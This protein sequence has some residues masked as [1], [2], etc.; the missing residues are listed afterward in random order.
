VLS[1]LLA[2]SHLGRSSEHRRMGRVRVKPS[3]ATS[4]M[5][6]VVGAVFVGIGLFVVIPLFGPFGIFWTLVAAAIAV[7]HGVNVFSDR[8]IATTEIDID[9]LPTI[10]QQSKQGLSFDERLRKLDQLRREGLITE[11]EYTEKRRE[12]MGSKW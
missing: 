4:A 6:M 10:A 7:F 2:L 5:G 9:G 12:V 3:K 11:S 8:G 1:Q